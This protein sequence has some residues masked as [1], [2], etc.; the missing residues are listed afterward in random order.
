MLF[1]LETQNVPAA[2]RK[3]LNLQSLGLILT[4]LAVAALQLPWRLEDWTALEW[5]GVGA[6]LAFT[7]AFG[8]TVLMIEY[9]ANSLERVLLILLQITIVVIAFDRFRN[10]PGLMYT[11]PALLIVVATQVATLF[12]DWVATLLIVISSVA[13]WAVSLINMPWPGAIL[14]TLVLI[15]FQGYAVSIIAS[16]IEVDRARGDIARSNAELVS[17]QSF[18][19]ETVRDR[20][21]LRIARDLHDVTGHKLTALKINLQIMQQRVKENPELKDFI[22]RSA[23]IADDLLS[24]TRVIVRQISDAE[25]LALNESLQKLATLLPDGMIIVDLEEGLRVQSGEVARLLLRASQEG[26]SNALRHGGASRISLTLRAIGDRFVLRVVDNGR[27]L[28]GKPAG[29]GRSQLAARVK[30][31]GGEYRLTDHAAAG[32]S[33]CELEIALSD[34]AAPNA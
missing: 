1:D 27:G 9:G 8:A 31:M 12:R 17:M 3:Q 16:R 11:V 13:F 19:A 14:P 6:L 25:G 29:F 15:A 10:Y 22:D 24:D 18:V 30:D 28:R 21:R 34:G 32:G 20:E 33:G 7:V 23:Q 26:V 2:T 4:I 5:G